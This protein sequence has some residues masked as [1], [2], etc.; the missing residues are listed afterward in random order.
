M[1]SDEAKNNYLADC[2][3]TDA[4]TKMLNLMRNF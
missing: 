3:I 2:D 4:N 1:L